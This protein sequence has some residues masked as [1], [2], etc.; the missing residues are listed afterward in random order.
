MN[1]VDAIRRAS[2]QA[3]A[4]AAEMSVQPDSCWVDPNVDLEDDS[5]ASFQPDPEQVEAFQEAVENTQSRGDLNLVRI[6]VFLSHEQTQAMLRGSLAT[7]HAVLTS[8]ELATFLRLTTHQVDDMAAAGTL[9]GF[10]VEGSWRFLKT[11]IDE[12]LVNQN[13]QGQENS[14]VA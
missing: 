7:R 4:A 5:L 9:P 11:A 1:L 8:R 10:Q 14:N 13:N 2:V 12:W 6:E 3:T